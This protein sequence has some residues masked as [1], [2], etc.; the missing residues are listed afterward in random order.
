MTY[1]G[2]ELDSAL[3]LTPSHFLI[4]RTAGFKVEDVDEGKVQSTAPDL[5]FREQIRQQQLDKFWK[6]WSSDYIRNLPPTVKG[7]L[8]KCNLREGSLVLI[9]EDNIPRMSWPCGIVLEVFPGKDG[10]IR[11]VKVKTAKGTLL[12]PIQRLHD[13]EL[14]NDSH[15]NSND[16]SEDLVEQPPGS[17]TRKGRKVK[18]PD[19]LNL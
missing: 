4:G 15:C 17:Y 11:S 2:D 18:P 1:V 19:R 14:Y 16:V 13:L 9:K 8:P 5:S 10:L 6:L 7:F 3:P 12:R